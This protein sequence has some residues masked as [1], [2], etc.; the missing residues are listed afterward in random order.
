[1]KSDCEGVAQVFALLGA[2]AIEDELGN[3][4]DVELIPLHEMSHPRIDVVVTVSGIFRDLL[5]H[6]MNLLD[7]AVRLAANA[8]EPDEFNFVR[9]H[10]Q[11]HAAA[12]NIPFNEA[13]TRVFS[14]A[15]GQYGANVNFLVESSTWED[16]NELSEAFMGRKSF[17]FDGKGQLREARAIM[18]HS[19]STVDATFQN[20]DSFEIGISDVDHY[21]EY[22]GGV[23]KSVERL[24]GQRP[25]VLVADA[26]S[27]NGRLS[28]LEQMVR[29]ESRA[30]LLNPK[31]YDAMLEHGYEG[32]SEIETRVSNTY[33]WSATTN[34]VEGW[35]YQDIA[36]TF[37]LDE[38][39]RER[40]GK[41]NPHATAGIARRLLEADARGFWDAND[42]TI[43]QLREI[44]GDLEDQME[45]VVAA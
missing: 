45:G 32:V 21:Y 4:S 37:L 31:W 23:T 1:L 35:V 36:E 17:A 25:P 7:K 9:K 15:P 12:L 43:E 42:E 28:S 30:K 14:N 13:A 44:Y 38:E 19:L 20:V 27:L 41:A 22:L 29:L 3:V 26:I 18:E 34:A 40:M 6:Q 8:P 39:M 24:R 2:R 16:D 5:H 10:T 11:A 33:G